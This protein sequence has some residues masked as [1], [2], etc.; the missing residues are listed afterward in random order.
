MPTARIHAF[1]G[2]IHRHGVRDVPADEDAVRTVPGPG[3]SQ[4]AHPAGGPSSSGQ[5]RILTHRAILARHHRG[6]RS[7]TP[8]ILAARAGLGQ[9]RSRNRGSAYGDLAAHRALEALAALVAELPCIRVE[10]N[11]D[12]VALGGDIALRHRLLIVINVLDHLVP[13]R[14]SC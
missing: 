6:G 14:Q 4:A 1:A 9:L 8:R 11:L 7:R 5:E 13:G 12:R 2:A 10:I 3:R